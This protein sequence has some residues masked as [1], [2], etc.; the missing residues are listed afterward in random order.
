MILAD[1]SALIEYYRP[2]GQDRAKS[3]V[4]AAISADT[5]ATNGIIQVEVVAFAKSERDFEKL[6]RDFRAFHQIDLHPAVFELATSLGF[7]L[8][9]QAITVPTT[10]LIIAAS[11]IQGDA[12]LLHLDR[13]FDQI[14]EHSE[15]KAS[16][17][18]Q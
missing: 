10:D 14:A 5:L 13:H 4:V 9:R 1:S 2:D 17:L 15:L 16:N 11:A 3:A 8:R 7:R 18:T 6:R 12:T